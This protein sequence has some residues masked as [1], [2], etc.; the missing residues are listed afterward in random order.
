MFLEVGFAQK[1]AIFA[2]ELVHLVRNLA[3]IKSVPPFFANQSQRF[4]QRRILEN[5]AL[6]RSTPFAV[7]S[8]GLQKRAWQP[9]VTLRTELPVK[10]NQL[11][12]RKSL[13]GITNRG[14]KM[15]R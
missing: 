10:R 3:F 7:Q 13:L 6:R 12:N 5:V 2:H 11:R 9:C 15:V 4:R 14:T 8:V 1:S